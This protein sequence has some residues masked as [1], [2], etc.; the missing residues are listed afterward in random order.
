MST[1]NNVFTLTVSRTKDVESGDFAENMLDE[2]EAEF[3][4]QIRSFVSEKGTIIFAVVSC[5]E[6]GE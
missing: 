2:Q 1:E 3:L 5:E 4:K 6:Q